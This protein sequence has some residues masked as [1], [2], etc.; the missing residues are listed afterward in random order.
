MDDSLHTRLL[1]DLQTAIE[2]ELS[3]IPVYLYTYYSINRQPDVS[4]ISDPV[5]AAAVGSFANKAGAVL[6]SVAVEEMLHMSLSSNVKK[7]LGG[8]PATAGHSPAAYPTNLPK[9]AKGFEI[10]LAAFS[11]A[12][13]N[14]FLGIEKPDV[15]E[16]PSD[17]NWQTIGQFYAEIIELIDKHT[18]PDDFRNIEFQLAPGKGYYA[19]NNIDAIYPNSD[20]KP[21]YTNARDIGDLVLVDGKRAALRA[22]SIVCHQGE[23]FSTSVTHEFDDRRDNEE[24]H[25]YKYE[26]LQQEI[27]AF[28]AAELAVMVY[29]F[30]ENPTT[31]SYPGPLQ[32]LSNFVNAVYTY[33]FMMT[34]ACYRYSDPVQSEIFNTGMHKGMIFILDKLCGTMRRIPLGD[35]GGHVMAPTFENY[36]FHS[37][38]SAKEQI[39]ALW[40]TIPLAYRPEDAIYQR[41]EALPD[42]DV[43]PGEHI[44]Y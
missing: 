8:A 35:A 28:S 31:A 11:V 36:H 13:L 43:V 25:Y 2:I 20:G 5:R 27:Q 9:H 14:T 30:P 12:Q 10:N 29:P 7:A 40:Q 17:H 24:T 42:V 6:M 33:L 34:D 18:Q 44:A 16:K 32:P 37:S 19:P 41:V 26:Q 39:L 15:G 1:S 3:T 21:V 23:G 38:S 4:T 22:I